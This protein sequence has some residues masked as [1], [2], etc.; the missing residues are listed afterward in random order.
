MNSKEFREKTPESGTERQIDRQTEI[1]SLNLYHQ[2][3]LK[4]NPSVDP[5]HYKYHLHRYKVKATTRRTCNS[6]HEN[7]KTA[8]KSKT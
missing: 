8:I 1:K 4:S 5:E 6:V 7:M 2:H 3:L